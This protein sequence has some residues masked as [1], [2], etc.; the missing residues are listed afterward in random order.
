M[1]QALHRHETG[2]AS[3]IKALK[4][5]VFREGSAFCHITVMTRR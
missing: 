2:I 3:P 1:K 5:M 4:A